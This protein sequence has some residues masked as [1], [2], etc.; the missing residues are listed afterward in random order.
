M[1]NKHMPHLVYLQG[2]NIEV[3]FLNNHI[4]KM[5]LQLVKNDFVRIVVV[6]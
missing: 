1:S 4:H 6:L 5:Y 2:I 3:K